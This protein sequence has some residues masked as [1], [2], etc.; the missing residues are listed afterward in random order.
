MFVGLLL[1]NNTKGTEQIYKNLELPFC[2]TVAVQESDIGSATD[3]LG[4]NH[5][6]V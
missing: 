5:H 3:I 1:T 2:K 4:I 6:P